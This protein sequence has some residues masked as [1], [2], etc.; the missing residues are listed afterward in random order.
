MPA[1][2]TPQYLEAEKRFKAAESPQ[3]KIVAL[4]EMMAII[5]KHK[6]TEKIRAEI[7]HKLS[8]LRKQS[9]QK[10]STAR[11]DPF[12]LEREGARQLALVGAPNAGKSSMV[13]SLTQATPEIADYPFTTRAPIPGMLVFEEVRLQL[14]DLPPV[15]P[16]HMESWV[17]QII[18]NADA[19]LWVGDLSDDAVL[20]RMEATLEVLTEAR[21][22]LRQKKTLIVGTKIDAPGAE[23]REQILREIYGNAF[24]VIRFSAVEQSQDA[25]RDLGR[26]IYEF[27][28]LV[29]VYTKAPGKKADHKDP[30]VL[31][32]GSTVL[33]LAG[34]V[35]RSLAN[36]L[37][38]A[39]VWGASKADGLMIGREF[40]LD[41][42]DIVEL[43][44]S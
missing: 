25:T 23:D 44:A 5:P 1:N 29:R 2:L 26:N 10:K 19:L 24:P 27:M 3:E 8:V 43:H 21:I 11:K 14:V 20:D 28:D 16:D 15:S 7:K 33:D 12:H 4:Q 41:D 34:V 40:V 17:P 9:T 13:A 39:K 31:A 35:H 30:F 42:G 38:F 37:K 36:D 32:R 22:D 18:D 6:G